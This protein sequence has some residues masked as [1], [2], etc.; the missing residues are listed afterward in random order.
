SNNEKHWRQYLTSEF[1]EYYNNSAD[2]KLPLGTSGVPESSAE[3]KAAADYGEG[4]LADKFEKAEY[5]AAKLNDA[6]RLNLNFDGE[7]VNARIRETADKYIL[8]TNAEWSEDDIKKTGYIYKDRVNMELSSLNKTESLMSILA[9]EIVRIGSAYEKSGSDED[10]EEK[11]NNEMKKI[12]SEIEKLKI[13]YQNA[14]DEYKKSAVYFD[15]KGTAYDELYTAV[16]EKYEAMEEARFEYEKQ[17]A[18]RRWASTAYLEYDGAED[19]L[20][21]QYK[22]PANELSYAAEKLQ[23]AEIVLAALKDIYDNEESRRPFNNAAYNDLYER[24]KSSFERLIHSM[25]IKSELDAAIREETAKN[26]QLYDTYTKN[27]T[28]FGFPLTAEENYV[29]PESKKD[30]ELTDIITVKNGRLGFSYS[31]NGYKLE[32]QTAE[33]SNTLAAYF[34]ADGKH[35]TEMY[36]SSDFE[37]ALRKLSDSLG[38]VITDETKYRQ[39]SMARDY[40]IIQLQKNNAGVDALQHYYSR[41]AGL[42]GDLSSKRAAHNGIRFSEI[43]DIDMSD[44]Q[45]LSLQKAAWDSLSAD[46]K[47]DM[48]FY[49]ILTLTGGGGLK[50]RGFKF[51]TWVTEYNYVADIANSDKNWASGVALV[52]GIIAAGLAVSAVVLACIPGGQG[53][54][55]ALAKRAAVHGGIALFYNDVRQTLSETLTELRKSLDNYNKIISDAFSGLQTSTDSIKDSFAEYKES[56]DRIAK[57]KGESMDGS[58]ATWQTIEISLNTA[59]IDP[60]EISKLKSYWL[61]MNLDTRVESRDTVDA[62]A[63]L[64]QWSRSEREDIKRDLENEYADAEA[65]RMENQNGYR[66]LS[67]SYIAGEEN[68]DTLQKALY[69]TY[70]TDAPAMKNHLENLESVIVNSAGGVMTSG[71]SYMAEYFLLAGELADVIGR[72]YQARYAAELSAR[73]A[74]WEQQVFDIDQKLKSWREAAGV[75]LAKGRDDWKKGLENMRSRYTVWIK[76]FSEEYA[77]TAALWDEAYLAGLEDKA[78]WV[79]E[80][81]EAV[82]NASGIAALE[83]VGEGAEQ[84]ARA[85]DTLNPAAFNGVNGILEAEK[86][87][88]NI[89]KSAGILNTAEALGAAGLSALTAASAARTGVGNIGAW[90]TGAVQL[91]AAEMARES[92]EELAAREAKMLAANFKRAALAALDNLTDYV[93]EANKN[94]DEGMD[95]TFVVEGRW[96]RSGR[97]YTN[98]ILV[99]ASV[100]S[101]GRRVSATVETFHYYRMEPITLKTGTGENSLENLDSFAVQLLI[102]EMGEELK[103]IQE[104]IFGTEDENKDYE[105]RSNSE[106][107][108]SSREKK[109]SLADLLGK[110]VGENISSFLGSDNSFSANSEK[111]GDKNIYFSRPG[112]FGN[113]IGYGPKVKDEPDVDPDTITEDNIFDHKGHGETGRLI[114]KYIYWKYKENFGFAAIEAPVWD[115]SLWDDYGSY[116]KAPSIRGIAEIAMQAVSGIAMSALAPFTGGASLLAYA[117]LSTAINMG[118]DTLFAMLDVACGYK[119]WDEALAS[120]AIN[121]ASTFAGSLINIGFSGLDVKGFDKV[122]GLTGTLTGTMKDGI[123]KTA[124][125]AGMTGLQTFTAGTVTS[126]IGSITYSRKGGLGFNKDGFLQGLKGAGIGALSSVVTSAIGSATSAKLAAL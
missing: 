64:V 11:I 117:G 69:D 26:A 108:D 103:Q 86:S 83:S 76:E 68:L 111:S 70:G 77:Q 5:E 92:N 4:S 66:A 43:S 125:T 1:L 9:G 57:L 93:N 7:K 121:T 110:I 53:A 2:D 118:D 18:I 22:N 35:E 85:L 21:E 16:K 73:E 122:T 72:A 56:C 71:S 89:L 14:I 28:T 60:A 31:G 10:S 84:K 81:R 61:E 116:F 107:S 105:E 123:L 67:Q 51:A 100:T 99:D 42:A 62:L 78:A 6:I 50:S 49:T 95:E 27:L 80:A 98:S 30:W 13:E 19:V 124:V 47:A 74:E 34:S 97:N 63:Q 113:H 90:N 45:L 114:S 101:G 33:K 119:E 25:K 44:D 79:A 36:A 3:S 23:R 41:D 87:L 52:N 59:E 75:I 82:G 40:L 102:K 65:A 88:N 46:E 112:L 94:F 39:W 37:L 106:K 48:E 54:A 20:T 126:A 15:E 120:L 58:N 109:A 12:E 104:K 17:D 96:S 55:G 38:A 29:S 24:Y 115:K 8:N 32:G 91:A